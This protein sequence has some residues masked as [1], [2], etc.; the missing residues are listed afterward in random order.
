MLVQAIVW[1]IYP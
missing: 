1:N